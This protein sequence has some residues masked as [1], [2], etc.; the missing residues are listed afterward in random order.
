M[1]Y[2]CSMETVQQNGRFTLFSSKFLSIYSILYV[3]TPEHSPELTR[4]TFVFLHFKFNCILVN[5]LYLNK[6]FYSHPPTKK[7]YLKTKIIRLSGQIV[8]EQNIFLGNQHDPQTNRKSK[9]PDYFMIQPILKDLRFKT[10]LS[11]L[12]CAWR[13]GGG[14]DTLGKNWS[15][16]LLSFLIIH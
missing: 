3:Y 2:S 16:F 8:M 15:N 9:K 14:A 11:S 7:V 13:K 10:P 12:L 4:T 6:Y 5:N 1:K